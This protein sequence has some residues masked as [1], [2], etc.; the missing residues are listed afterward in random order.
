MTPPP[1]PGDRPL[2]LGCAAVGQPLRHLPLH[3]GGIDRP[4][5]DFAAAGISAL[6]QLLH[7]RQAL[8]AVAT[9]AAYTLVRF[10]QLGGSLC[11]SLSGMWLLSAPRRCWLCCLLAGWLLHAPLRWLWLLASWRRR[12]CQLRCAPCCPSWGGSGRA[13]AAAGSLYGQPLLYAGSRYGAAGQTCS[14]G[15]CGSDGAS[16]T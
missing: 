5:F 8:A 1:L 2:L 15:P 12:R 13:A 3:P 9:Q 11:L 7:L 10:A 16:S 6:G 4:F 14:W